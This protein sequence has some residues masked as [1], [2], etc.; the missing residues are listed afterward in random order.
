HVATRTSCEHKV[1][2]REQLAR[3]LCNNK[4]IN[5]NLYNYCD[6]HYK[7]T[8]PCAPGIAYYGRGA[9]PIYWNYNYGEAGKDLKVD[10]L[11][12]PEYIEQNATLAFQV[13]IWRW[14]T[15][16]KKHQPSAHNVFI[17]YWTPTKNDTLAK[18]V[19]GFGA[20]M[21]V[22]YGD[23][24][25]GQVDNNSMNNIISH[26]LHYLDLM[27][28]GREEAGPHEVLSCAKQVAFNPS[29]SSSP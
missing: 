15:P 8:Y 2:S 26:Y 7:D 28:V 12:H 9:L 21:N 27:G 4:E 13:A 22:L 6:Q 23:L 29:F 10:L 14:M 5:S 18:R 19:S 1:A 25:C 17:G 11:N 16:I 20:T 24:I 3:G